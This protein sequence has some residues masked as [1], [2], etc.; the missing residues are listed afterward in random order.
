MHKQLKVTALVAYL[1]LGGAAFAIAE[2]EDPYAE[3]SPTY[4]RQY[5]QEGA[6]T[7]VLERFDADGRLVAR[8]AERLEGK[9]AIGGPV[10]RTIGGQ[11]I[12]LRG[13]TACPT[14][15]VVYNR[16]QSWS[17]TDAA[18]DYADAVYNRRGSV[19]LCKTLV[20][21]PAENE[22]IPASCFVLVG[23]NGEPFKTVNDDDSMV[24]L[25]LA[26][27]GRTQDGRSRRPDLEESQ[28]LSRS[29]GFQ[30]AD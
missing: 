8:S 5:R 18:R 23:G 27:I 3:P 19:V 21:T 13:L 22:T 26:E 17:C 16:V 24:F 11:K 15:K 20:L 4:L 2:D 10:E 28:S 7:F 30:N 29:M 9:V 25:G 6:K 1:L 12:A 14:D